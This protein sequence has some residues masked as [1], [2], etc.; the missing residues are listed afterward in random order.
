MTRARAGLAAVFAFAFLCTLHGLARATDWHIDPEASVLG[1]EGTQTGTPFTGRFERFDATIRF[2]PDAP[3]AA[4]AD[5][6]IDMA[7]AR[8]GDAQKDGALPGADWFDIASHKQA[9]FV[10]EGF[11]ALGGDRFEAP[12][13]LELRGTSLPVV[14]PFTFTRD[15]AGAR[16]TGALAIDRTAYGV[17]QGAWASDAWVGHSVRI[18]LDLIARPAD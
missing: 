8:T 13:T 15:G 2:D 9:R 5:V 14:L 3:E 12:G 11:R 7:S 10:A 18:T 1:F 4:R 16:V 17:G 6:V